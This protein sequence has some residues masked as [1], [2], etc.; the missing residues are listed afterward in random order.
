M[1]AGAPPDTL[2]RIFHLIR[3][4]LPVLGQQYP[5]EQAKRGQ[6]YFPI[7]R[8]KNSPFPCFSPN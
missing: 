3:K 5:D 2:P 8:G 7:A 4:T 1:V 6:I